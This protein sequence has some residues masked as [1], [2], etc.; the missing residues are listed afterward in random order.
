MATTTTN[1][2]WTVPTSTDL[3]KNG[4]TA[5]STL[6]SGVDTSFVGLKGGTTGQ[7]LSKSSGTDLAFTWINAD[8]L[9]ILDAKGDLI[10]ATAADTPARL[11][12]GTTGQVLTVDSTTSTGLKW[13][14]VPSGGMTLLNSGSTALSG[15][16]ITF[17]SLGG[18]QSLLINIYGLNPSSATAIGT[19]RFNTDSANNYSQFED[20]YSVGSGEGRSAQSGSSIALSRFGR[21]YLTQNINNF[22]SFTIPNYSRTGTRVISYNSVE[23][24]SG[25]TLTAGTGQ[26]NGGSA[27]TSLTLLLDNG[28]FSAGTCEIWGLK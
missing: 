28:S 3:V 13:A 21:S 17:S 11:A 26:Y 4:A 1:F 16:S 18:Y 7:V 5:I 15:S 6:G 19:M 23:I 25:V 20:W 24:P 22:W 9:T 2:G 27:I 10:T 14:A 8:P 12:V